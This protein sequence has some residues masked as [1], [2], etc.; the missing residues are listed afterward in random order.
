MLTPKD[1]G[2]AKWFYFLNKYFLD[3]SSFL[4][5]LDVGIVFGRQDVFT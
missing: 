1:E 4:Y 2:I 3:I 5:T